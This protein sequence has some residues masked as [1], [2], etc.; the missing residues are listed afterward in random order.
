MAKEDKIFNNRYNTGEID[1][2]PFPKM[3]ID[4]P[5]NFDV[6]DEYTAH[7]LQ[8][9]LL[10]I[11]QKAPFFESYTNNRKIPKGESCKI[12]YYFEDELA[13]TREMRLMEKFIAVADFMEIGYEV[14]YKEISIKHKETLLK[15]MD[16]EYGIFKK[17]NIHRLF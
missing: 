14:L 8:K 6:L 10:E 13:K 2:E 17:R 3:R 7:E 1:Y 5:E 9:H 12:F 16:D 11:F 4:T 15:E